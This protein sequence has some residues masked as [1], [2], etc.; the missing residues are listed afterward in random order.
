MDSHRDVECFFASPETVLAGLGTWV[1]T[2]DIGQVKS[3]RGMNVA[4]V[5]TT[6][7]F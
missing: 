3:E 2:V 4:A 6:S 7:D 1:D 5:A